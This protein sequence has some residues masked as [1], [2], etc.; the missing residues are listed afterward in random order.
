ML[1]RTSLYSRAER[2]F[3]FGSH[4]FTRAI[5]RGLAFV[6][7]FMKKKSPM[8]RPR[9]RRVLVIVADPFFARSLMIVSRV[10][11]ESTSTSA[12]RI[13]AWTSSRGVYAS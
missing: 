1:A 11:A 7:L 8:A 9:A 5:M 6:R 13:R 12:S 3:S 10:I 4:S 2:L